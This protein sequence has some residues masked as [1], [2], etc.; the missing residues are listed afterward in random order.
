MGGREANG[1]GEMDG[2]FRIKATLHAALLM[3]KNAFPI[4]ESFYW[5]DQERLHGFASE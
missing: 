1:W 4:F 2:M 5:E 3:T